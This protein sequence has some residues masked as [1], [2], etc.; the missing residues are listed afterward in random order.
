MGSTT[1]E[2]DPFYL[3][4]TGWARNSTLQAGHYLGIRRKQICQ[5]AFCD[6]RGVWLLFEH[7]SMESRGFQRAV[8]H[9]GGIM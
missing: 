3:L 2:L 1:R 4:C 9:I 7:F 5:L 8:E 6:Y